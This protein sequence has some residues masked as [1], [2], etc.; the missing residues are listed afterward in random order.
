MRLAG[1]S[2]HFYRLPYSREVVWANAVEREGTFALL[3]LVAD[4]GAAGVAEG[5]IKA[6]WSGVSPRSLAA[7]LEDFL[8][9]RIRAT[10]LADENAVAAAFA[11]IPENRLAKGMVESACW[12]L[13]AAAARQPLWSL[14]GSQRKVDVAWTVTRQKPALMAAECAQVCDRY[15]FR[16]LKVKGG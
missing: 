15:G 6:T 7:A 10:D 2:L 8:I 13:R 9:P 5:T 14:W 12:T 1:W 4:S 16:T 11:G 3:K